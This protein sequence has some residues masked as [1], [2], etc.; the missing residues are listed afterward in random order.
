M[1][2]FIKQVNCPE[3]L[4]ELTSLISSYVICIGLASKFSSGVLG[5]VSSYENLVDI[6]KDKVNNSSI[7]KNRILKIE[8]IGFQF[9]QSETAIMIN[10][11]NGILVIES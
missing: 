1:D 2:Q 5:S 7:I 3:L 6:I 9:E 8:E 11:G 10:H 4:N